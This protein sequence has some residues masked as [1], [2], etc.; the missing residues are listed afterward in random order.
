M[1]D[2]DFS[3]T[4]TFIQ[5]MTVLGNV[6][7]QNR[8]PGNHS[9]VIAA[10]NDGGLAN[11]TLSVRVLY[12]TFVGVNTNSALVHV[13]NADGTA[14]IAEISNNII[15]GTKTPVLI[16]D[17]AAATVSGY[18]S[19]GLDAGNRFSPHQS[20]RNLCRGG[21]GPESRLVSAETIVTGR[22][23]VEAETV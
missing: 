12:N 17:A 21:T 1:T 4:G 19:F 8:L 18:L 13:S 15:Y 3:G 23:G 10:Y 7:V 2:D 14:M 5:T 22:K 20:L 9:Q 11:L 16:E 6:F